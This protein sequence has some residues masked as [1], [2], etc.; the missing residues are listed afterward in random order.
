MNQ[1][2]QQTNPTPA[3]RLADKI[4]ART[5]NGRDLIDLM[6]DIA[7]GGYDANEYDRI[8]AS[9]ILFDRGYGKCP[10]QAPVLSLAE[11]AGPEPSPGEPDDSSQTPDPAPEPNNQEPEA[12]K[13]PES[14]RLVTQ[15]DNSLHESL[16]PAPK[17]F[18]EPVNGEPALSLSKGHSLDLDNS[19]SLENPE[20]SDSL[21]TSSLQS[22]IQDYI[23]EITNDGDTL[24]D[25]LMDVAYADPDNPKVRP[26]HRKYADRI[27]MD[28]A[29]GTDPG[30]VRNGVCPECRKKWATHADSP[31]HPERSAAEPKDADEEP[32]DKEVWDGIIAELKQLEEDG[33]ITPDPNPP[34]LNYTYCGP[35]DDYV[36]PPEVA[37]EEA[38]KFRADIALRVE[39]QKNWPEIEE[40]RRKKLAQIYPSHSD[41][42]S[43]D[44]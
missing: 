14:P 35:P 26:F 37:A 23:I 18:P 16:G 24:V 10:K 2:A 25:V 19:E 44:T 31:A 12:S 8:T 39:R 11:E 3:Q 42:E 9:K 1:A 30:L 36:I 33:V 15:L 34:K 20:S 17:A 32:F 38:A 40:R 27:L 4:L 13:E 29:F 21:D 43:P 28:R 5:N 22:A 41:D 6:H 7:Q